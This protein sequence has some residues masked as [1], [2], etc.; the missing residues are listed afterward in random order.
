MARRRAA[1]LSGAGRARRR[2]RWR[3]CP[4]ED[5]P[6]LI[7]E[8]GRRRRRVLHLDRGPGRGGVQDGDE[9]GAASTGAISGR[10][11][12]G[13]HLPLLA[14]FDAA[15]R[16]R[17][18]C[19]HAR[20]TGGTHHV[21]GG[22]GAAADRRI[23]TRWCGSGRPPRQRA[24]AVLA[25]SPRRLRTFRQLLADGQHLVP[26]REEQTAELTLAWPVM[27]RAVQRIG[28]ALA[29]RGALA[30]PDDVFFLT[31]DEVLAALDAAAGVPAPDVAAPPCHS[32]GAGEARAT[33]AHRPGEPDA[34][35]DVG[36]LSSA[37]S[38]PCR[39]SDA[40]VTG[41]PASAGIATGPVRVV[42]GPD[43]FDDAPAGRGPG[44]AADR[45]GL[46]AA[47]HARRRRSS[48]TSA[49]RP[50]MP[51]SSPASTGSRR[52]SAA[53]TPPPGSRPACAS[54]STA[55]RGTS[56]AHDAWV[57]RVTARG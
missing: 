38:A 45:A 29:D 26:I 54:P 22:P 49:A 46:D 32:R 48:P 40:L 15:G 52:S 43:E 13:S 25:S 27:R 36:Q 55:A 31:R 21:G 5:L 44:G 16:A 20:S 42:R 57:V 28:Q 9:P 35:A 11:S 47:L 41:S 50:P 19:G 4:I 8:L 3:P 7:D 12:G 56:N 30:D 37:C 24:E 2:R 14:G 10:R 39:R 17:Q 6:G 1:A 33:A 18:P 34:Q 51:R 23:T 53:A